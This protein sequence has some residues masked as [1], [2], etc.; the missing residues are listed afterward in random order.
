MK[1]IYYLLIL[2]FIISCGEDQLD[3]DPLEFNGRIAGASNIYSP[4]DLIL[5]YY[6]YPEGEEGGERIHTE[7]KEIGDGRYEIILTHEGLMDDSMQGIRIKMI[8]Q[9][10]GKYW[11]VEEIGKTWKCYE[12]RGH[13]EWGTEQCS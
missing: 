3:V 10:E 12:G 6:N 11:S 13:T 4:D 2:L 5:V 9:K 7:S 8:A 1:R